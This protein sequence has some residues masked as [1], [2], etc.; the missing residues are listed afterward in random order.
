LR[1]AFIEGPKSERLTHHLFAVAIPVLTSALANTLALN[2]DLPV[3]RNELQHSSVV[4]PLSWDGRQTFVAGDGVGA[5]RSHF[6]FAPQVRILQQFKLVEQYQFFLAQE[7]LHFG[8]TP[9]GP[10]V[11]IR[12]LQHSADFLQSFLWPRHV[13]GF[14]VG[15]KVAPLGAFTGDEVGISEGL[16]VGKPS[17]GVG[18][19][20]FWVGLA[21]IAVGFATRVAFGNFDGCEVGWNVG[22]F[23]VGIPVEG[24]LLWML[25]GKF[26]EAVEGVVAS[27]GQWVGYLVLTAWERWGRK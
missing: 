18:L 5:F 15:C 22:Y 27:V 24:G 8:L 9:C 25:E 6:L 13:A 10:F 11:Q 17:I 26:E 23:I 7:N 21:V 4:E 2:L 3:Q 19:I 20:K 16:F 12:M 14:P 1:F